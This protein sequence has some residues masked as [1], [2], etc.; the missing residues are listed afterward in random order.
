MEQKIKNYTLSLMVLSLTACGG[1]S[2]GLSEPKPQIDTPSK[3]NEKGLKFEYPAN[4]NKSDVL[5]LSG[6][7]QVTI[8]SPGSALVVISVYPDSLA[9]DISTY[10][11]EFAEGI[12]GNSPSKVSVGKISQ[13]I[14]QEGYEIVHFDFDISL[15]GQKFHIPVS[16]TGKKLGIMYA[17]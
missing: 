12:S 4:W 8:E 10:A 7:R 5:D 11:K 2:L 9:N 17:L 15:L 13:V 16:S 6:I 14:E 3:Y 1:V